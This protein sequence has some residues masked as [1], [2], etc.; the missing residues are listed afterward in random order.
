MIDPSQVA[1]LVPIGGL[2]ADRQRQLLAKAVIETIPAGRVLFEE[3]SY[4]GDAYFVLEGEVVL[5][6]AK[7]GKAQTVR[8]GSEEAR[9]ALSNYRPR[10]FAGKTQTPAHIL[11]VD[12]QLLDTLLTWDQMTGMEVTEIEGDE[13]DVAWMR[14]LLES[15]ALLRM[16]SANIEQLFARFE[17]VPMKAGQILI[18][19]GEPGDYYYLVK[20]GRCRVVQKPGDQQKMV[21]LADLAEG[22]SFGEEALLSGAPRNATIAALT[23]GMLMRLSHADFDHLLREPLVERVTQAQAIEMV[24][25]GAGLIDVRLEKEFQ[26]VNLRGSINIPLVRLRQ[27]AATLDRP[28]KY[29]VYCDTGQRSTAAAFLLSERG[30]EVAVLQDGVNALI[31]ANPAAA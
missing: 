20:Q 10:Q 5:T 15:R 28:R 27:Q 7:G 9:Y 31:K 21:A 19:Q 2:S 17:E 16:P 1:R 29:I 12:H 3:G 8:G 23:D 22:D 26:R 24:K 11:H 6:S 4:D 13:L 18:R 30:F 25:A 14:R